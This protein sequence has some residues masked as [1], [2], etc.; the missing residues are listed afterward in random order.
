MP[1]LT[2][3]LVILGSG[4]GGSL[5]ALIL[6]RAGK[7]VAM[8]DRS[9]HPKFA[10]GE[11]STPLA[12]RTLAQMADEYGIPELRPLCHRGAWKRERTQWLCGK[13]RGFTYF[14]QTT[15]EDL[16]AENFEARRLLVSSSVDDVHSD[17]YW[18]RRYVDDIVFILYTAGSTR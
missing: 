6:A 18:L 2:P 8:V 10:S 14:D 17:T 13:K 15:G 16:T 11:S 9:R 7:S 3:D 4:F 1:E 5:L 12:D